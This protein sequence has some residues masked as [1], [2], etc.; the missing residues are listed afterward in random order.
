MIKVGGVYKVAEAMVPLYV[1]LGLGYGSVRWW[2][3]ISPEQCEA[4]NRLVSCI[5]LPLFTFQ[6]TLHTDPFAMNYRMIGADAISKVLVAALLVAWPTCWR[7]HGHKDRERPSYC[8]AI[9]SFSLAQLTNSLVV[10]V[11]LV[12]AMY[13]PWAQDVVVQLSV[14]QA[15]VWLTLL[16][17]VFELRKAGCGLFA[18]ATEP[19]PPL[20][21]SKDVEGAAGKASEVAAARPSFWALMKVVWLKLALNPNSYASIIGITWAFVANRWHFE[22]PRIME[23]SILIMSK[24]GMGMA[25][26]SMGLFMALQEKILACGPRLTAYGMVLK[27]IAGPAAMAIGSIAVGIRGEVLHLAIIQAA[28]PQSI[29]SFIFA[30][31]Y[32]LHADVLSTAVIFGMLVSLPIIVAYYVIL[33]FF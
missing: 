5:T 13:G 19:A 26:Y 7:L 24:A 11:P 9:T 31:E 32:Q 6:F 25:M 33:G 20:P 10:G 18:A 22:M 23:G 27:F 29:T 28:L 21:A 12:A 15:I 2:R 1:A 17:F 16:L 4:I 3:I 30:R 8:W 14:V